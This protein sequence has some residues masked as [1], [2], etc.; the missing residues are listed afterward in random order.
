[1][2]QTDPGPGM[3]TLRACLAGLGDG[4]SRSQ[5]GRALTG[6]SIVSLKEPATAVG[7]V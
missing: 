7:T 3:G 2:S 4:V 1:M 6:F 5:G